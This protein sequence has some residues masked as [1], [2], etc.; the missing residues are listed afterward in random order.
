MARLNKKKISKTGKDFFPIKNPENKFFEESLIGKTLVEVRGGHKGSKEILFVCSN[1]EKFRLYHDQDC[2]ESVSVDDVCGEWSDL[3]GKPL[4][5]V[6]EATSR[7]NPPDYV[8]SEYQDSFTWTFYRLTSN[9]GQVV[10]RWYGESNGY[11]S[12]S[13]DFQKVK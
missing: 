6:E 9:L 8:K 13:V 1:G 5:M 11:Y 3:I 12:E 2:C 4:L 7:D 10:I